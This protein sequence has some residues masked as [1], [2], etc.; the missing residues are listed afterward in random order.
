MR[1]ALPPVI[2]TLQGDPSYAVQPKPTLFPA[3]MAASAEFHDGDELTADIRKWDHEITQVG[4]GRFSGALTIAHTDFLQFYRATWSPG[5]Y[6]RGQPPHGSITLGIQCGGAKSAVWHGRELASNEV[7]MLD[8]GDEI[9]CQTEIDCDMLVVSVQAD[10][11]ARHAE[12]LRGRQLA[13]SS[14]NSRLAVSNPSTQRRVG[15]SLAT[16][17]EDHAA[18][19]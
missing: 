11:F 2:Q 15:A 13:S 1:N 19:G 12:T 16:A 10:V 18:T 3:G 14:T 9:D 8:T 7:I 5:F 4:R 17:S 6:I